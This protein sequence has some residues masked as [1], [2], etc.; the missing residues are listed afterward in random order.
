MEKLLVKHT[1]DWRAGV[2]PTHDSSAAEIVT[3][4]P[5]MRLASQSIYSGGI[6]RKPI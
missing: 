2:H 1:P 4:A 5:I 3:G 6:R